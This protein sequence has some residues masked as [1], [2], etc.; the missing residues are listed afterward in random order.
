MNLINIV[1]LLT[2]TM[3]TSICQAQ[4][5]P[6]KNGVQYTIIKGNS[7]DTATIQAG[8]LVQLYQVVQFK[9]SVLQ[10]SNEAGNIFIKVD[11]DNQLFSFTDV[12]TQMKVGD[13]SYIQLSCDT[14][15]TLQKT[16]A[17]AQG[18]S[19]A[20]FDKYI[21][22]MLKE[23][24]AYMQ[25]GTR[26]IKAYAYDSLAVDDANL[27]EPKRLAYQAKQEAKAK[28][29]QDA[30]DAV[31]IPVCKAELAKYIQP[32]LAKLLKTKNG[33]YVQLLQGG[34]GLACTKGSKVGIRYK[35]TL[36]NGT[37]F[38]A[39]I[40]QKGVTPTP[41]LLTF[42]IGAKEMIQ[43]FDEGIALLK[44]GAKAKIYIPCN[45]GYGSQSRGDALPAY[46]NLIFDVEIVTVTP[47][48]LTNKKPLPTKKK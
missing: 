31:G 10:S 19:E 44:K 28:A 24:G 13:S 16:M 25:I 2:L 40:P 38:D 3:C 46:A 12:Y 39:N 36:L 23:K 43:G 26:I 30:K 32:K 1:I 4:L 45:L 48:K 42:T 21:P 29:E 27:Q 20:D 8:Q 9:D 14:I 37:Q 7:T 15:Y 34:T 41:P 18:I 11:T 6:A 5:L 22:P 47:P 35:G 33:A 17:L